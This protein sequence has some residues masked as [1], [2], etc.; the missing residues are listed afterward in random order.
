MLVFLDVVPNQL[1]LQ[2]GGVSLGQRGIEARHLTGNREAVAT[3]GT[4]HNQARGRKDS[5]LLAQAFGGGFQSN[6]YL[7]VVGH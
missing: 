4:N 5:R 6:D 3:L 1:I 7:Y 2:P